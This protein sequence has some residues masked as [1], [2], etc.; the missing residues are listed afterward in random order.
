M[1]YLCVDRDGQE[2]VFNYRPVR[3][4]SNKNDAHEWCIPD[5]Y[6]KWDYGVDL[7]DHSISRL[8]GYDL[9]WD[10]EPVCI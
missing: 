4:K 6:E 3:D 5:Y 7:P 10:D 8:I 9:T 1:A 2:K